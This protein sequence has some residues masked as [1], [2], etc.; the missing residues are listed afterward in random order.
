MIPAEVTLILLRELLRAFVFPLQILLYLPVRKSWKRRAA[1]MLAAPSA[2]PDTAASDLESFLARR[3]LGGGRIFISVGETSGENLALRLM[4][5][6]ESSDHHAHWSCFGGSRMREA[7]AEL[8][9][10]LTDRP[11]MGFVGALRSLPFFVRAVARFLRM[12]RDDPPD[13]VVLVDYP[14]LHMV[15]GQLARRRGV[16]VLHYVA[17]QLWGWAPW[18][19]GRY[20]NCVDAT[21]TILPFE[22]GFF[23]SV[24]IHC[25]YVGHPL[26][27]RPVQPQHAPT[28][29][30]PLLCLLPGSRRGEIRLHLPGMIHVAQ[31]LRKQTPNLHVVVTHT[32]HRRGALIQEILDTHSADFVDFHHGPLDGW[33]VD[34]QL[35]VAKS[36]TGALEACFMGTPTVIAY[37]FSSPLWLVFY[38]SCLNVPFFGAANLVAGREVV[39][40]FGFFKADGWSKVTAAAASLLQDGPAR[41]A[42]LDGLVEVRRRMGGPG[43]SERAARWVLPF[44]E[45]RTPHDR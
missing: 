40:E 18:R 45:T 29:K 14:G 33:L 8:L 5:A 25:E 39:P 21:L 42:C 24:G 32:D 38:P 15:L 43:A 4:Q 26:L 1:K 22:P 9:Y 31:E 10:P 7:G 23:R 17:P 19:L 6:V 35:V 12:L 11:V 36:G 41:Q 16:P 20:R 28:G 30:R 44:C 34:A 2:D 27:D 3:K 37:R 13:L